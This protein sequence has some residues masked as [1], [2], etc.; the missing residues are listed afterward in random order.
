MPVR[1]QAQRI[2]LSI[3]LNELGTVFTHGVAARPG[4]PVILGKINGKIIVGVPGYPVSAYLALEWFV[5]P[6]ICDYLQIP[7]P[8]RQTVPVTVR[9]PDCFD[10]GPRGFCTHEYRLCEWTIHC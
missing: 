9:P 10:N 8:K 7:E 2:T 5:R 1:Q 4:K 3:S 6:L